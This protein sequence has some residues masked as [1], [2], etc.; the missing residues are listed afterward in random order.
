MGTNLL[1]V[2]VRNRVVKGIAGKRIKGTQGNWYHETLYYLAT[3]EAEA[4]QLA[5]AEIAKRRVLGI[6]RSTRRNISRQIEIVNVR[7]IA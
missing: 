4:L 3:S 2:E 5:R 6:P 7:R 1:A